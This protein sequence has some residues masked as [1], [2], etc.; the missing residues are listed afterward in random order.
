MTGGRLCAAAVLGIASVAGHAS[1]S[2]AQDLND[3]PVVELP[4]NQQCATL[5]VLLTGDGGWSAGEKGMIDVL[6]S[7]RMPIVGLISP[8]YLQVPR[9]PDGASKDLSRVLDRYLQEW[10]CARA[11]VIGYSR[12]ADLAPFMVSRL[13]P[14]LRE[15]VVSV[16]MIGLSDEANFQYRP[17]DLFADALRSNDYPILPEVEKLKGMPV[18]CIS[19]EHERG[20][21]CPSL[22]SSLAHI[23]THAGGHRMT[24]KVA[25]DVATMILEE[26]PN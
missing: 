9:S 19:G 13:P 6:Q 18:L 14:P 16:T 8:S 11:M 3:L 2:R 17:I 4:V 1:E 12:G 21:L 26:T 10:G 23:A 5:A 20:S 25:R 24:R 22:D 7:R 15:R